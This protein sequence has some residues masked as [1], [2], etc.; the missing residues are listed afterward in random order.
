MV[1]LKGQFLCILPFG[2]IKIDII[3]LQL[4]MSRISL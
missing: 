4:K 2:Q 1:S 3:F